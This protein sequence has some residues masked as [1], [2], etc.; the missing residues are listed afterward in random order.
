MS[1]VSSAIGVDIHP[2]Y[3]IPSWNFICPAYPI[4]YFFLR[5]GGGGGGS[6]FFQ[7]ELITVTETWIYVPRNGGG[8]NIQFPIT[9]NW[10]LI[11][12]T[13]I[14]EKELANSWIGY[15]RLINILTWPRSFQD[16]LL[17]LVVFSLCLFSEVIEG[18][19]KP[20]KFAISEPC[21]RIIYRMWHITKRSRL[22]S[23]QH[24]GIMHIGTLRFQLRINSENKT[25]PFNWGDN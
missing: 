6:E 12:S 19:K 10:L 15:V 2:T 22:I 16:K 11:D 1:N 18:Q 17:Y 8:C 3:S 14:H 23:T 24:V 5:E 7:A 4:C 25:C 20:N 21:Y 9:M 13:S